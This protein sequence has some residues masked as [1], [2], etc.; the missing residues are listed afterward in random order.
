MDKRIGLTGGIGSGKTAVAALLQESGFPVLNL[1]TIG[2]EITDQ[3]KLQSEIRNTFGPEI[4]SD[5]Q[6]D[7]RKL[8]TLV[9]TNPVQRK[10]LEQIL[11]PAIRAEFERRAKTLIDQGN[12]VVFCEAALLMENGYSHQLDGLV[13][14]LASEETRKKRVL[15]RDQISED[16][17]KQILGTQ[18]SDSQR[19]AQGDLF[20]ENNGSL[21]DLKAEIPKLITQ[22]KKKGW[23]K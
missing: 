19:K 22:M 5:G 9:F 15:Q 3:P 4:L 20:I 16:Q 8:R 1:D 7:R 17:W 14:V 23:L 2:K 18:V 10:K 21:S 11:H 6:I 12:S 13:V